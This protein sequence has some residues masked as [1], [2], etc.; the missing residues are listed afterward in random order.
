MYNLPGLV[1]YFF[2]ALFGFFPLFF[3]IAFR[4]PANWASGI[5]VFLRVLHIFESC[6]HS[7]DDTFK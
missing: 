2:P 4:Y 7:I 3:Q 6:T 5:M 1:G